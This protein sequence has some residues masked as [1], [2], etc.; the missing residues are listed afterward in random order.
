MS[1]DDHPGYFGLTSA[2]VVLIHADWPTYPV[3]HGWLTA[4]QSLGMFPA[5]T[6]FAPIDDIDRCLLLMAEGAGKAEDPFGAANYH[7]ALWHADLIDLTARQFVQGPVAVTARVHALNARLDIE[8]RPP[9]IAW[10]EEVPALAPLATR[11]PSGEII[12]IADP[13]WD[14]YDN[15]LA[16]W[17]SF[18]HGASLTVTDAGWQALDNEL[19]RAYTVP[20]SLAGRLDPLLSAELYDT[21]VREMGVQLEAVLRRASGT[22]RHGQQ[23]VDAFSALLTRRRT[24]PQAQIKALHGELRTCFKFVRNEFAHNVVDIPKPRALA[25]LTHMGELHDAVAGLD[26]SGSSP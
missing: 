21:A 17:V 8:S 22:R 12:A 20:E 19:S 9:V 16:D 5:R 24:L 13:E 15:E 3:E 14:S 23:L 11:L 6:T 18:P 7:V 26:E 2:G 4:L 10:P 25:L 1:L